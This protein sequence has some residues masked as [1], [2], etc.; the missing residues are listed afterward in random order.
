MPDEASMSAASSGAVCLP[1]WQ[2]DSV[3]PGFDSESYVAAKAELSLIAEEFIAHL[4]AAP[5]RGFADARAFASWLKKTI[6]IQNRARSLS[7]TLTS[8]CYATYSTDTQAKRAMNELNAIEE[9]EVPF[10]R[11]DTVYRDILAA[12]APHVEPALRSDPSLEPYR[13]SLFDDLFWQTRQMTAAEEDLAAD[14]SRSGASAWGRLQDQMTSTADCLWD[15]STGERKTLVELRSLAYSGDRAIRARAYEKELAICRSIGIPVASAL[16]GVKGWTVSLNERRKW[17]GDPLD[18]ALAKSAKQGLLSRKS[19][20]ALIGSIEE[21]LP[22]WRR[23]LKA[24]ARFLCVESCAFYDL[25]APVGGT[26]S[27][28]SFDE[29]RNTVRDNF[30][31]FSPA[32]GAFA[33]RAFAERWIDAEPRGGKIGGAYFT[34][35]PTVKEGR[36]LCNFDGTFSSVLTLAHELGHAYHAEVLKDEP[37]LLQ[38]HPMTLAETASIFAETVVFED[39]MARASDEEKLSLIEMHLQDG[40]QTLVDILSRYYFESSVFAARKQGELTVEDF[41]ALMTDAQKKT[42]GDG[43]DAGFLHPFMWLVKTHYYSDS[44]AFYN[45]PYAFGQLF[46]LAL[47]SRYRAEGESF[48]EAYRNILRDTG[49]MDAIAVTARAGF[50]IEKADFWRSGIALFIEQ[51]DEFERLV[52]ARCAPLAGKN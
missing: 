7:E 32:M 37:A 30:A 3:F 6:G 16:N 28:R 20:D 52:D 10:S 5:A 42:Y 31:R 43:L 33:E 19:L 8:Y 35:M 21:S 14:L 2:L 18:A 39:E 1:R 22:H 11:A 26:D 29:A 25:F 40:C 51:I 48:A 49:S 45:F 47:Y 15:E 36:V 34:F 41:C 27:A 46:A 24:K 12:N 50:D 4:G 44:L 9:I 13:N 38:S 23:Y 17:T